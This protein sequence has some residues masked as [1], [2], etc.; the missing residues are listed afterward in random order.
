MA[1]IS[2]CFECSCT[3]LANLL[4]SCSCCTLA[5]ATCIL[6]QVGSRDRKSQIVRTGK[7]PMEIG[8]HGIE[9]PWGS[10][11][12]SNLM[13]GRNLHQ[14]S[15]NHLIMLV[16]VQQAP[17]SGQLRQRKA[18]SLQFWPQ[19]ECVPS[20]HPANRIKSHT[21]RFTA[22][23][24]APSNF[25]TQGHLIA[26][27]AMQAVLFQVCILIA[28]TMYNGMTN[29]ETWQQEALCCLNPAR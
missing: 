7:Q 5:A 10:Q 28:D 2:R 21:S 22:G 1:P 9:H 18:L 3:Q 12:R 14:T 23:P 29:E 19:D 4:A 11:R 16:A 26:D 25:S 8:N 27:D 6:Q 17:K 20:I 24:C 13:A 15:I